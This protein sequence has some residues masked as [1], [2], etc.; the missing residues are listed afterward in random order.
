MKWPQAKL[1][2]ANAA[3]HLTWPEPSTYTTWIHTITFEEETSSVFQFLQEDKVLCVGKKY[4]FAFDTT[5]N[6]QLVQH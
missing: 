6:I 4:L 3:E 1:Q 5:I 2:G